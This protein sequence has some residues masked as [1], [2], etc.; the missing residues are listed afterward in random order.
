MR[1]PIFL[2][3]FAF[4]FLTHCVGFVTE[5]W[6]PPKKL[7]STQTVRVM[8][9]TASSN[10]IKLTT[11]GMFHVYDVNDLLIKKAIDI[12]QV[13]P[14]SLKARIRIH[15]EAGFFTYQNVR[16]RGDLTLEPGA[17]GILIL[18][19]VPME[20]YLLSVVPSEVP[21]S[22]PEEA[23]KAQAVCARTYV[24]REMIAKADQP[25]DVVPTTANQV[26]HG[27]DKENPRTTKAVEDTA[28]KIIIY[29]REPIQAFFHSNAGGQ[30]E[31]SEN[32][33]SSA[34]PYLSYVDSPW[35]KDA[36]NYSWE[37]RILDSQMNQI[38]APLKVGKIEN[39]QVIKR[40]QSQ[41][42][43]ILEIAGD[44]STVN[45]TGKDFRKML[46]ETKIKSLKF[47]IKKENNSFYLKGLGFGHGVGMSQWGAHGMAKDNKNYVQIIKHYY[48]G[49][50]VANIAQ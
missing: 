2:G 22:W 8:L 50:E 19:T 29:E 18:N 9:G 32:V 27:M 40:N 39:I 28:G 4:F 13:N 12:I 49:V 3:L 20:H 44:S 30:T 48:P 33:W 24:L 34:L 37:D 38:F 45:I 7:S 15:S 25:Y 14:N 47:G 26:Y 41:R 17:N 35:D 43:A 31:K 21:S 6:K 23:L 46:G 1:K 42:V 5:T 16:Y 36:P 11:E 10:E